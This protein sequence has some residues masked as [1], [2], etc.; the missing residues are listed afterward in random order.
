MSQL[1]LTSLP[2]VRGVT[3]SDSETQTATSVVDG[4]NNLPKL[5]SAASNLSFLAAEE[6]VKLSL[7]HI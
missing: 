6:V 2:G 5:R 7:I 4:V 1:T 3:S